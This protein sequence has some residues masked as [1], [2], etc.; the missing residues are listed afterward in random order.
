[1]ADFQKCRIGE[2]YHE[3]CAVTVAP[4]S[5]LTGGAQILDV[6]HGNSNK[7]WDGFFA[8]IAPRW[9]NIAYYYVEHP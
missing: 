6:I 8:I 4:V 3:G 5:S 2:N 7:N 1:M 9:D